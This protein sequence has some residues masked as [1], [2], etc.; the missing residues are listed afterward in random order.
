MRKLEYYSQLVTIK[1]VLCS[2]WYMLKICNVA[3]V[4]DKLTQRKIIFV[5]VSVVFAFWLFKLSFLG[6]FVGFWVGQMGFWCLCQIWWN[7]LISV[8]VVL[9]IFEFFGFWFGIG[10]GFRSSKISLYLWRRYHTPL[11]LSLSLS[12]LFIYF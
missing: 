3:N 10:W 6:F 7:W 8:F 5:W 4:K 9:G 12:F 1:W 2:M 11:S